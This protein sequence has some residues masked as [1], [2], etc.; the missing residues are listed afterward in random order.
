[1]AFSDPKSIESLRACCLKIEA[2]FTQR[3]IASK[4]EPK[5]AKRG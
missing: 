5:E 2:G 3:K 4:S 1:M